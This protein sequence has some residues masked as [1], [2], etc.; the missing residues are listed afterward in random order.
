MEKENF[1]SGLTLTHPRCVNLIITKKDS[2]FLEEKLIETFHQV[3]VN[4]PKKTHELIN[5]KRGNFLL[6]N[7]NNIIPM[8]LNVSSFVDPLAIIEALRR[9]EAEVKK[10]YP[11][12]KF[13]K[14]YYAYPYKLL[15]DSVLGKGYESLSQVSFLDLFSDPTLK[16]NLPKKGNISKFAPKGTWYEG[17]WMKDN[18]TSANEK[19]NHI[20]QIFIS[21]YNEAKQKRDSD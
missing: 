21:L 15:K 19:C 20:T 3:C 4:E 5:L 13:K 9:F 16:L 11:N 18:G 12:H 17:R 14:G 7:K 2:D 10:A 8:P 1:D 6:H